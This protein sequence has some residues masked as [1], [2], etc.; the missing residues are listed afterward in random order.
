M[1]MRV[2]ERNPSLMLSR[3]IFLRPLVGLFPRLSIRIYFST[4]FIY[5]LHTHTHTHTHARARTHSRYLYNIFNLLSASGQ[6]RLTPMTVVV[7][8]SSMYLYLYIYI[9][10]IIIIVVVRIEI[11]RAQ[12]FSTTRSA[13]D[14]TH[15]RR[16]YTLHIWRRYIYIMIKINNNN[17]ESLYIV[18]ECII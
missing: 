13:A 11:A 5:L 16:R 14:I 17:E 8:P 10:Y 6:H 1:A 7:S 2:L 3:C 12:P 18:H 4:T 9:Y 15:T